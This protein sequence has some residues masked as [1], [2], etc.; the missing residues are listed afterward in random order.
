MSCE[1]NFYNNFSYVT[2]SVE[3]YVV[4]RTTSLNSSMTVLDSLIMS[5]SLLIDTFPLKL[6]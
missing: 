4:L 3:V 1:K 5:P 6:P 2:K